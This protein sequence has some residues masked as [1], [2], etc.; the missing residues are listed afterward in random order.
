M[1]HQEFSRCSTKGE[2]QGARIAYTFN[3]RLSTLALKSRDDVARN[4]K[5]GYQWLQLFLKRRKKKVT[6]ILAVPCFAE[7][8]R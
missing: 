4:L 7:V 8:E 3:K 5:Q 6:P 1:D 2:S